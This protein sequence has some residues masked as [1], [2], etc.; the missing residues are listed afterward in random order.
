[1]I[2][3]LIAAT[4]LVVATTL[5]ARA[6]SFF[7]DS[8]LFGAIPQPKE[9]AAAYALMEQMVGSQGF[10]APRNA[11]T[12]PSAEDY[13][14]R[15]NTLATAVGET[16]G[17]MEQAQGIIEPIYRDMGHFL[18]IMVS[19]NAALELDGFSR[20]VAECDAA[21]GFEPSTVKYVRFVPRDDVTIGEQTLFNPALYETEASCAAGYQ[22]LADALNAEVQIGFSDPQSVGVFADH[23]MTATQPWTR[24]ETLRARLADPVPYEAA[25]EVFGLIYGILQLFGPTNWDLAALAD[26]L[27]RCDRAFGFAPLTRRALTGETPELV[28][29]MG[30]CLAGFDL[31]YETNPDGEITRGRTPLQFRERLFQRSGASYYQDLADMAEDAAKDYTAALRAS[32]SMMVEEQFQ[33]MVQPCM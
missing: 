22:F 9:C 1:M 12:A 8:S 16:A 21:F 23:R 7:E 15:K 32:P 14:N 5:P 28:R 27:T 33:N 29:Q 13:A 2:L 10:F 3:R 11:A 6:Q 24:A 18:G 19:T 17:D 31:A 25:D 4:L 30:N 20:Y 26:G